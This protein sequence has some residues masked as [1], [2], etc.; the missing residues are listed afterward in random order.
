VTKYGGPHYSRHEAGKAIMN[1]VRQRRHGAQRLS[2]GS[3]DIPDV[4]IFAGNEAYPEAAI[5]DPVS[6]L[7]VWNDWRTGRRRF[8]YPG[9]YAPLDLRGQGK[10]V[11]ASSMIG[12]FGEIMTGIYA[13]SGIGIS[14]IARVIGRWP[15]L[16]MKGSGEYHFVEAKCVIGEQVPGCPIESVG[17]HEKNLREILVEALQQFGAEPWVTVWGSFVSVDIDYSLDPRF[18]VTCLELTADSRRAAMPKAVPKLVTH[19]VS[20]RVLSRVLASRSV[21]G[22]V[23][24]IGDRK[25]KKSRYTQYE[26]SELLRSAEKELETLAEIDFLDISDIGADVEKEL[27]SLVERLETAEDVAPSRFDRLKSTATEEALQVRKVGNSTLVTIP[28]SD[29]NIRQLKTAWTPDWSQVQK[30]ERRFDYPFYRA[31]GSLFGFLPADEARRFPR[32]A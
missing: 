14:P 12:V 7:V 21:E 18:T 28:L 22:E 1:A 17:N 25:K 27:A 31:G 3:H 19:E 32:Y 10:K 16:I 5:A 15:D 26:R 23:W 2:F 30:V 13:Q 11:A 24:Q 6:D 8:P 9:T 29:E 20:K 4:A